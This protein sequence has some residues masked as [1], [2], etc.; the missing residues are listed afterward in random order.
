MIPVALGERVLEK[1]KRLDSLRPFPKT[2]L[3]KLRERFEVEWTYNSNAIEGNTLTLRETALVLQEGL[4]IGG[5]SV[6]EHLEVTNHKAAI[7]FVYGLVKKQRITE[8]DVLEVHAL[9][10]DRIDPENA[11]FYRRHRVHVTGSTHFFPSPEKVPNLMTEFCESFVG[12]PK[13]LLGVVEFAAG[14]HFK[15]VDIHPFIDGN[16]RAARLL[17]N[18][19]LIRGGFPPA[20]ILKTERLKYYDALEAGHKGDVA[21][22]AELV[23]RSV[24]RSL[25]L[26]L[27][28]LETPSQETDLIPLREAAG[29]S[30]YSQDYLS[31]RARQGKLRALK[32][33][34]NWLT[35]R[36]W[37]SDY[38]KKMGR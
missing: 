1:R 28:V 18:L 4:T 30:I 36:K 35:T 8:K 33:G 15:L 11:G 3:E 34:R 6:R 12:E 13:E 24:E 5:K 10:L 14:A 9:V 7:E 17:M 21:P 37:V 27:E 16:G 22:F 2:S 31:L 29:R 32:H 26:Y 20:V 19:F 38:E 25:D 23:A